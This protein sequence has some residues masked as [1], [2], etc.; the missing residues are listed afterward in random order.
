MKYLLLVS[1][2]LFS[3]ST[4]SFGQEYEASYAS[5]LHTQQIES[6]QKTVSKPE[7]FKKNGFEG[8]WQ[9]NSMTDV[10]KGNYTF[11]DG[12]GYCRVATVTLSNGSP[13]RELA[14]RVLSC[15]T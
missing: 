14:K 5:G 8:V 9:G 6:K 13:I 4:I 12:Q 10:I 11:T 7:Q 15:I 3:L 1:I 2:L